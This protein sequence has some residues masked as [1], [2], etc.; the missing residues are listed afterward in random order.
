[1]AAIQNCKVCAAPP[2]VIEEIHRAL[3]W[4]ECGGKRETYTALAART[5]IARSALWRHNAKCRP[6]E[7]VAAFKET[8]RYN[9]RK[10]RIFLQWP[11]AE[12]FL[13]ADIAA[14]R[15]YQRPV[16]EEEIENFLYVVEYEKPLAP[17]EPPPE[18][19]AEIPPELPDVLLN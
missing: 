10:H 18:P 11:G 1:M 8:G 9:P 15:V 5:G 17:R 3:D 14:P 4:R 6:H 13:W 19:P 2:A 7:N 12:P 16:K